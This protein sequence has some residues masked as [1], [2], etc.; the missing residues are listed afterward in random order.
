MFPEICWGGGDVPF[1]T[2]EQSE[3]SFSQYPD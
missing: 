1:I 3:V 2:T